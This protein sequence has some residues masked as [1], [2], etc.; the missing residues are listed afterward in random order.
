MLGVFAFCMVLGTTLPSS[1]AISAEIIPSDE[2]IVE[3]GNEINIQC[4]LDLTPNST[5]SAGDVLWYKN[6]VTLSD[7]LYTALNGSISKLNV[8]NVTFEDS[9]NYACG[10]AGDSN[11][12][13]LVVRVGLPP[14][15]A[16]NLI[17]TAYT[18]SS[19]ICRWNDATLDTNLWTTDEVQ[20]KADCSTQD[21]QTCT[22]TS[23]ENLCELD[24]SIDDYFETYCIRVKTSNGLGNAFTDDGYT[25]QPS[26]QTTPHPPQDL[27][28][29]PKQEGDRISLLVTWTTPEGLP[30]YISLDYRV[31]YR[32]QTTNGTQ[33]KDV[34]SGFKSIV[35]DELTPYTEYTIEVTARTRTADPFNRELYWS[36]PAVTTS[37]T[38]HSVP[39]GH[40]SD[41]RIKTEFDSAKKHQRNV[42]LE[43]NPVP[44]YQW[45]SPSISYEVTLIPQDKS[46][47]H[48]LVSHTQ[49]D[50]H[51]VA[52]FHDLDK[53]Q[54][55]EVKVQPF[56]SHGTGDLSEF[57][58]II[59]D[60]TME[61]SPPSNLNASASSNTLLTISWGP[62]VSP[63]GLIYEY[64]VQV[65]GGA[66]FLSNDTGDQENTFLERTDSLAMAVNIQCKE[67]TA[68]GEV[69]QV[70]VSA[71]TKNFTDHFF[72]S[73]KSTKMIQGACKETP[74]PEEFNAIFVGIFVPTTVIVSCIIALIL[75]NCFKDTCVEPPDPQLSPSIYKNGQLKQLVPPT[76]QKEKEIF[77]DLKPRVNPVSMTLDI[78]GS[79]QQ[80]N[81]NPYLTSPRNEPKYPMERNYSH[82]SGGTRFTHG[83]CGH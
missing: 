8:V 37:T 66:I 40:P 34:T 53:Y 80:T 5:Q 25:F 32:S 2:L 3:K 17:C 43:W 60:R 10:F 61:P 76:R 74:I 75:W 31:F 82:D 59:P 19:I 83:T 73:D 79:I 52:T 65:E 4:I 57:G 38:N 11:K 41:V 63:N 62:P 78:E 64:E 16:E 26:T 35:L 50:S 72:Y 44:D 54:T 6:G 45:G 9:G 23:G 68:T 14:D 28:V 1:G 13:T 46:P 77:D 7:S 49:S 22:P 47:G 71:A 55:Y 69:F 56:N 67:L 48:S 33:S 51:T 39:F 30:P 12:P 29:V 70:W 42:E 21:W 20:Y 58:N 27:K 24:T 36:E 81:L 15:K 18:M